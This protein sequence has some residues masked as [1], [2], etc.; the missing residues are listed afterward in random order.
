MSTNC[1]FHQNGVAV[2]M[3]LV[4]QDDP[5]VIKQQA[6]NDLRCESPQELKGELL[7]VVDLQACTLP[8]HLVNTEQTSSPGNVEIQEFDK[9]VTSADAELQTRLTAGILG[10]VVPILFVIF[11]ITAISRCRKRRKAWLN[12][13][14]TAPPLQAVTDSRLQ[15]VTGIDP[16]DPT[17]EERL[18]EDGY[19]NISDEDAGGFSRYPWRERKEQAGQGKTVAALPLQTVRNMRASVVVS[20]NQDDEVVGHLQ[21]DPSQKKEGSEGQGLFSLC[22]WRKRKQRAVPK[23]VLAALPLQTVRNMRASI[24][25]SIDQSDA[26]VGHLQQDPLQMKKDRC[27]F[28]LGIRRK[29]KQR[30]L[31]QNVLA[32]FPLQTLTNMSVP[33]ICS[34][35][36]SGDILS[37][38]FNVQGSSLNIDDGSVNHSL[39]HDD[40][41]IKDEDIKATTKETTQT[42]LDGL[43]PQLK[44][45]YLRIWQNPFLCDCEIQWIAR[46][47]RCVWEHRVDG[48]VDAPLFRARSCMSANCNFHPNGVALILDLVLRDD[49]RVIKQQAEND[50]RCESPQE[51]KGELLR[52]VDLQAYTLPDHL[53]SPQ[54]TS[55]PGKVG[56]HEVQKTATSANAELQ[57]RVTYRWEKTTVGIP[58]SSLFWW[59]GLTAGILGGVVPILFVICV[60]TAIR[61]CRKRRK[62]WL[63]NMAASL[64]LPAVTDSRLQNITS[65]DLEDSTAEERLQEEGYSTIRDEDASGFSRYPWREQTF[66]DGLKP[67]LKTFY[68]RIWQNPFLC[69]C[70]I[71]W[72]A[73]LRRCVWEHRVDGC[74]D[75]PLF[76]ARA[77]MSANCNFHPNGVALILDGIVQEKLFVKQLAENN[78]TCDSPQG[79]KRELLRNVDLQ[80]R[81]SPNQPDNPQQVST[82]GNVGVEEFEGNATTAEAELQT[83]VTPSWER[84]TVGIPTPLLFSWKGLTVGILGGFL[85]ILFVA[86]IMKWIRHCRKRRQAW[87]NYLAAAMPLPPVTDDRLQNTISVNIRLNVQGSSLNSDDLSMDQSQQTYTEIKDEDIK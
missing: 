84:T 72:I 63:N 74:V 68:L 38:N 33:N 31:P 3:D 29:R 1:N 47:R 28:S 58:K 39:Q 76:R 17:A 51:L 23:N 49:P 43:K 45:F 12:N 44:T 70:E 9:T 35:V 54:Q 80:V 56:T 27:R 34:V 61:R 24:V 64:P 55:S 86:F 52:N 83:L 36:Q 78:L 21:Q 81:T 8:D 30:A 11:I 57:T 14:A 69:D 46:L 16:S 25:V 22:T 85:A 82:L 4:L 32:A 40:A 37:D 5:R 19:S 41:E 2:I 60:I 42:F 18:G 77:C 62:A 66:L 65:V 7:R 87:L 48:C 53:R 50:L 79:L 73:R 67:Q 75:A 15:N 13:M 71:Q 6:E 26:V 10:G 20:T 59:K